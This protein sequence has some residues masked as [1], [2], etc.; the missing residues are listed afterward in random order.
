M[1]TFNH[2]LSTGL[3]ELDQLLRGLM[4]GDNV[5]WQVERPEDYQAFV[6]PFAHYAQANERHLIYFRFARHP[7][8]LTEELG[9]SVCYLDPN[10]GFESFLDHIHRVI[11][12]AGKGVF[13]V[14]DV[15]QNS[16]DKAIVTSAWTL[17][18]ELKK[19]SPLAGKTAEITKKLTKGKQF[20]EVKEIK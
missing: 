10:D 11:E 2:Q 7:M 12:E 20:F 13:Y 15:Q 17:L 5:V 14:F 1:I 4:P 16:E 6:E 3:P 8:L 18:H 19:L 9:A